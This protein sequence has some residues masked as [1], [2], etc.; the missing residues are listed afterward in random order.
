METDEYKE[1]TKERYKIEAKNAELKER[2]GY[3]RSNGSGI[4][5]M[6][7]QGAAEHEDPGSGGNLYEQHET[8]FKIGRRKDRWSASKKRKRAL[9]DQRISTYLQK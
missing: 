7:I 2:Y 1:L 6:K 3:G 8:D 4:E 5:S 9:I